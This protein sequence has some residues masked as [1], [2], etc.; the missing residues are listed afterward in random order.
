[1]TI[2]VN[3]IVRLVMK[4]TI[5]PNLSSVEYSKILPIDQMTKASDET[6]NITE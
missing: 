2:P 5:M 6:V 3:S 1:M 4:K